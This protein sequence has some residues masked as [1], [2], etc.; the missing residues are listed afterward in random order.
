MGWKAVELEEYE[1]SAPAVQAHFHAIR[2]EEALRKD[3]V[4]IRLYLLF[5]MHIFAL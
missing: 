5:L 3:D 2:A 1:S 4:R